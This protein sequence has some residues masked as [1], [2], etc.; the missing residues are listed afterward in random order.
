MKKQETKTVTQHLFNILV[1]LILQWIIKGFWGL[2]VACVL[3]ILSFII[4][5]EGASK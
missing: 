3:I 1:A 5:F 2:V 4:Y